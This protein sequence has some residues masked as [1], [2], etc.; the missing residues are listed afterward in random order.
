MYKLWE[1]SRNLAREGIWSRQLD[2]V[3]EIKSGRDFN[4]DKISEEEIPET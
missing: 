4:L 3:I 1:F 2:K